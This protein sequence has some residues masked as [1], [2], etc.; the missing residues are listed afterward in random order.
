MRMRPLQYTL[1][2]WTLACT[3]QR[4][5][6]S[7]ASHATHLE[8]R[9]EPVKMRVEVASS[10]SN[11]TLLRLRVQAL[12]GHGYEPGRLVALY[13]RDD[14]LGE[15]RP[16]GAAE[17]VEVT[18]HGFELLALWLEPRHRAHA[19]VVGPY[20]QGHHFGARIGQIVADDRAPRR[21]RINMGDAHGVVAGAVY[22][23][24]GEAYSDADA[25]GRSLG[26]ASVGVVQVVEVEPGGHTALAELRQGTAPIGAFVRHAGQESL[27]PRPQLRILVAQFHGDRG[28]V[29]REAL[30]QALERSVRD[31]AGG[32]L[33]IERDERSV[34]LSDADDSQARRL[35][36]DYRADLVVWGS[37]S[38]LGSDVV[39]RPRLLLLGARSEGLRLMDPLVLDAVRLSRAVPD[40]LSE[41]L[42]GLSAY[43]I[44]QLYVTDFEAKVEGSYARAAAHFRVAVERGVAADAERAEL[45]LFECLE[46]IGDWA[47]A[48]RL[49][50][51]VMTAG[52]SQRR[53]QRRAAG[54]LLRAR[55]NALTGEL[56]E[57]LTFAR[58]AADAFTALSAPRERAL[59]LRQVAEILLTRG[60]VDASLRLLREELL[61]TFDRLG[62]T[63]ERAVT[64]TK[65]ANIVHLR[66]GVD[67][68]LQLLRDGVLPALE[69]AGAVRLRA[70]ALRD[71]SDILFLRGELDESLRLRRLEVLPVL[72]RL[73]DRR[74]E[75]ITL[76]RIADVLQ[77]R[78]DFEAALALLRDQEL[79]VLTELGD[80]EGQALTL[81]R[82]ADIHQSR[83]EFDTALRLRR[84]E[85]LPRYDKLGHLRGR[86]A[87]L[88]MI[89][90]IERNLGNTEVCLRILE[91]ESL[92]IEEALGDALGRAHTLSEIAYTRVLLG[93][94]NDA[95]NLYREQVIPAYH[96]LG[97]T[98]Y[99]AGAK[100]RLADVLR[101]RGELDEALRLYLDEV[102][103]VYERLDISTSPEG[104]SQRA[105]LLQR[106]AKL[107]RARGELDEAV[108]LYV[109][110]VATLNGSEEFGKRAQVLQELAE[111]RHQRG[112]FDEALRLY[113]DLAASSHSAG[114]VGRRAQLVLKLAELRRE[115]GELDEA[116]QLYLDLVA[117]SRTSKNLGLRA[118]VIQ[119]LAELRRARGEIDEALRLYRDELLPLRRSIGNKWLQALALDAIADLTAARGDLDGAIR[120]RDREVLPLLEAMNAPDT[121]ARSR[122]QQ[123]VVLLARQGPG[124]RA[125]AAALLERAQATADARKL[126]FASDISALR[127]RHGL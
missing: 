14:A 6:H 30:L 104:L 1:F 107:R 120:I 8:L 106:L 112:E 66:G 46:R 89:A 19:L 80:L 121:L 36:T 99:E 79:P 127:A 100:G 68:A 47:G 33:T 71:I 69:A 45:A 125:A 10:V 58:A 24:L 101:E 5:Q 126:P 60:Q 21:V 23:V 119:E 56:D 35:A 118:Q 113:L 81:S 78:R 93:D 122:W 84:D 43:L 124:D 102:I 2:A 40:Q 53:P 55:I 61:P 88:R 13:A 17:V 9:A 38:A 34:D 12:P 91:H 73:G 28:N 86:A 82:I 22:T 103:P 15:V 27:T 37:A 16:V 57:A 75:A 76:G 72:E 52:E 115:R 11:T 20:P 95:I 74:E 85:V 39:V 123:A 97:A 50:R 70:L 49:A 29:Y 110:A 94:L 92:P 44:G 98:I 117:S 108:R 31:A 111:L 114:N 51:A 87:T 59:A 18:E 109:D 41:H 83:G 63:R 48:D 4:P 25:G 65:I 32:E 105:Q 90:L 54:L 64:L 62:D 96:V 67:E 7:G 42:H 77:R 3:H 116:L 26:R